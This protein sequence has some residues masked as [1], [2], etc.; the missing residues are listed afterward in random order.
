MTTEVINHQP[1]SLKPRRSRAL[2]AWDVAILLVLLFIV[3]AL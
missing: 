3:I 1:S 2:M